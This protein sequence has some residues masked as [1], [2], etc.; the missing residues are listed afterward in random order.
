[1]KET[2]EGRFILKN[3][4]GDGFIFYQ[5]LIATNELVF[6]KI[7]PSI[8]RIIL[9]DWPIKW[10]QD[11]WQYDQSEPLT[12]QNHRSKRFLIIELTVYGDSILSS[13]IEREKGMKNDWSRKEAFLKWNRPEWDVKL[14]FQF[15]DREWL[16][17]KKYRNSNT[18]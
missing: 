2:A 7:V 5:S 15:V 16:N 10:Q 3:G 8:I 17:S 14:K 11:D 13:V 9:T 12:N 1:M 6:V 18:N 4:S